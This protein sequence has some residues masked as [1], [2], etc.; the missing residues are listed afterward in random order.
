M[1]KSYKKPMINSEIREEKITPLA[2]GA[3]L[4]GGYALGRAV[5]SVMESRNSVKK[6]DSIENIVFSD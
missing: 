2:I 5:K 6:L 1:K 3:A 4:A